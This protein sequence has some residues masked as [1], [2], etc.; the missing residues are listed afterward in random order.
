MPQKYPDKNTRKQQA[1]QRFGTREPKCAICRENDWRCLEKDHIA[2]QTF[3]DETIILC[4]NC[5]KRR[6]DLQKDHPP[7]SIG[8]ISKVERRGRLLLG[9]SDTHQL[10]SEIL[11]REG[12]QLI[13]EDQ[14]STLGNKD[15]DQ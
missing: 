4:S 11:N 2:G 14:T 15:D 9:L 3:S 13:Q 8:P 7:I 6:T 1:H 10:I 12:C 5:H